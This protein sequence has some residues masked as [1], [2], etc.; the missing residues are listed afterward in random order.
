MYTC[1]PYLHKCKYINH[2]F[3]VYIYECTYEYMYVLVCTLCL[4]ICIATFKGICNTCK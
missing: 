2:L 3:Y 4:R 1:M